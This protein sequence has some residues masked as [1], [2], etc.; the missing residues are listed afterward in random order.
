MKTPKRHW[1][2]QAYMPLRGGGGGGG[3]RGAKILKGKE[4][5]AKEHNTCKQFL[6]GNPETMGEWAI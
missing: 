5:K 1:V 6:P 4:A 3:E 2:V